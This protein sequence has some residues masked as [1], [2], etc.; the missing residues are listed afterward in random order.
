M[1]MEILFQGF[2]GKLTA[3]YM[4]WSAIV[5]VESGGK[6]ILFD[7]GGP[8]RRYDILPRLAEYGAAPEDIDI[9]AIS[10]FH[11]DHIH[12]YDYF[13]RAK[14][15]LH[16][17]E[18]AYALAGG[19]GWTPRTFFKDLQE[20][21]KLFLVDEGDEIT[22]GVTIMHTPG[23]TPGCMSALL[24]GPD[25]PD[26]VLAGDAVKNMAELASGKA[27]ASIDQ[28]ATAKSILKVR[29]AAK[30]VVPG[31]DRL[32]SVEKD[33]IVA[34]RPARE[35]I[36]VPPGVVGENERRLELTLEITAAPI[37]G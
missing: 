4:Q 26:T 25:F 29:S 1:R 17:E 36:V 32:L 5:Y 6:K 11:N 18:M 16:K 34:L 8:V 22:K 27:A 12:N 14:F 21:G 33:R 9:V 24:T 28:A 10:H 23:H 15:L 2:P 30:R 7:T 35:T 3:G 37:S 31:H 19:D 20:S 13:T